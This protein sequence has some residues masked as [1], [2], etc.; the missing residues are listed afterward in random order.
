MNGLRNLFT[1]SCLI[2]I[3]AVLLL[4]CQKEEKPSVQGSLPKFAI[5]FIKEQDKNKA[6]SFGLDEKDNSEAEIQ[7]LSLDEVPIITDKDI[8]AFDWQNQMIEFTDE[9]LNKHGNPSVDKE[10]NIEGGS[11]LLG[12]K[13]FDAVVITV[14][15]ERIYKARFSLSPIRSYVPPGIVLNDNSNNSITIRKSGG[16]DTLDQR[17]D[18]RVRDVFQKEGKL[19]EEY[20]NQLQTGNM[21]TSTND[22]RKTESFINR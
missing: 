20:D 12:A 11:K 6:F 4:G 21:N 9:Y 14:N 1:F 22:N 17:Y 19:V 3:F 13:E 15:G 8:K 5:Y 10:I 2:L 16:N 7:E 18:K